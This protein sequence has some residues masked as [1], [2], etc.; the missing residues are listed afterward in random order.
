MLVDWDERKNRLNQRIHRVRFEVAQEVFFDPNVVIAEDHVGEAGEMRYQA[1]GA[2]IS[3]VV[4]LL[5]V[6]HVYRREVIRIISARKATSYE[7]EFYSTF[8]GSN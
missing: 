1:I 2:C 6:V 4:P 8:Q 7:T 3:G 5:L